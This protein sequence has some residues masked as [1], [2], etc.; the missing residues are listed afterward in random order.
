MREGVP[1]RDNSRDM[2]SIQRIPL[3][4]LFLGRSPSH[5]RICFYAT[6]FRGHNNRVYEELVP[7]LAR[8]DCYLMMFPGNRIARGLA[9]RLWARTRR[10]TDALILR[11]ASRHYRFL[12]T[13]DTEQIPHFSGQIVSSVDDPRFTL[14]EVELL[15]RPNVAAYIVT[16]ARAQRQFEQLGVEK[17]C[18]IISQGISRKSLRQTE[19]VEVA[20]KYRSP[21]EVV[22]GYHAAWLLLDGDR[23]GANPL[24]NIEHLLDLWRAIR[25][26]VP[27]AR[28][29]LLG[30]ASE[31]VRRRCANDADIVLFGYVPSAQFLTYVS[32]FDVGLYPRTQDMG[33]QAAKLV[34]YM[35]LGVPAVAYDF[36]VTQEVREKGAGI[37][38]KTAPEFV[39]AVVRLALDHTAR[40][41]FARAAR[42]AG[43]DLDWDV[44]AQRYVEVLDRHLQGSG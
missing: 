35:A 11:R 38:V 34:E 21:G 40:C 37:L 20:R 3:H 22:I 41:Q 44:L 33:I 16:R 28:L 8:L 24:Y 43:A 5:D 17:P 13:A 30:N 10:L 7:R 32:N 29:W 12:F 1:R 36:E 27:T 4:R 14:R 25:R 19:V 31:R 6:W 9:Y 15:N 42:A 23:D 26:Q 2:A 18:Y 39:S